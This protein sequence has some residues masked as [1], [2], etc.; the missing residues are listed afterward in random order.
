VRKGSLVVTYPESHVA[1]GLGDERSDTPLEATLWG[2]PPLG[3]V[4]VRLADG[5]RVAWRRGE[6]SV[7]PERPI[8]FDEL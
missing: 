1:Y 8:S 6:W 4:S 3:R 2:A 5:T 7:A